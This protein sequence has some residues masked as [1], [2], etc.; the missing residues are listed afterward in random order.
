MSKIIA[1]IDLN[2]FFA[3]AE[4]IRHPDYE[5]KPLIIGGL[6]S[7]GVVSTASYEARKYGVHSAMPIY[8]AKEKCPNGIFLW[9]DFPY[10][11]MLSDSFF[12]YLRGFSSLVERASIDEG[13]VDLTEQM[14]G[15]KDPYAYLER[16]RDGLYSQIG[17]KCS[18]G[19]AP[20]KWMAKMASDMK[21]P[22]G[23]TIIRRKDLKNIIY[24]L[25]I[26]SFW[27]IGKRSEPRLREMGINTIGD[28]KN[29]IDE[30]EDEMIH[31][32]GKSFYVFKDWI[33]GY[34]DDFVNP[35]EPDAKS[36][37][38]S[39]TFQEDTSEAFIIESRIKALSEDVSHSLKKEGK[40]GRTISIQIKDTEF[41]THDKSYSFKEGTDDASIIAKK[42]IELYE[43]N[44]LGKMARLIG[45]GVSNIFSPKDEDI[46]M[47][48][49]N[50]E[51]YEEED[52]T[53]LL[54]NELNRK[55][56]K[57]LLKLAK[58]INKKEE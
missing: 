26:S 19:V 4:E 35:I 56:K 24:P 29:R 23:I 48:F 15:I 12:A 37:S 41:K 47:T 36:I 2:A 7:R 20:T 11:R 16:I 14:K 44:F 39:E 58:D 30:N 57:P 3:R 32:F 9:P 50:F 28:L 8:Q 31:F 54:V 18:I 46:Q 27:G 17:L 49:D 45:V 52:R 21:K 6:S 38:R 55:M 34:G 25:P 40:K 42:A 10:Y 5:G 43:N 33:N 13:Y 22:M 51:Q 1:H 53:K